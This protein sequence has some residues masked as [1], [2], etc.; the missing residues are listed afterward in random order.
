[1]SKIIENN[2]CT[3]HQIPLQLKQKEEK[4]SSKDTENTD[5]ITHTSLTHP[6]M[7][8]KIK[9]ARVQAMMGLVAK[10]RNRKGDVIMLCVKHGSFE[11][12]QDPTF[13]AVDSNGNVGKDVTDIVLK[14][15]PYPTPIV[16]KSFFQKVVQKAK[17]VVVNVQTK[18]T[19]YTASAM[20][21]GASF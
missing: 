1:M 3:Q 11:D 19:A 10:L 7:Q 2:P 18:A 17:D 21:I 16:K 12:F 13:Y 14:A 6:S 9:S 4:S 5:M 20:I 15:C 8:I